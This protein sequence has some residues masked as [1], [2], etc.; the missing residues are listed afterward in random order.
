MWKGQEESRQ[1]WKRR[2]EWDLSYFVFRYW[3]QCGG[4][5]TGAD[6]QMNGTEQK[7]RNNLYT[8]GNSIHN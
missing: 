2:G 7:L 4:T 3:R 1:L 8:W 5:G 6:T